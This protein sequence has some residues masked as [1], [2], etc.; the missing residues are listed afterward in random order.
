MGK[1]NITLLGIL[2][3]GIVVA[4]IF[5]LLGM[6]YQMHK[7]HKEQKRVWDEEEEKQ[8]RKENWNKPVNP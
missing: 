4:W 2:I 3:I 8:W 6:V 1:I 5:F 7:E